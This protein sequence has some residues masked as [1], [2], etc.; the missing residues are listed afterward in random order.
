MSRH[1]AA[2]RV[3]LE[4]TSEGDKLSKQSRRGWGWGEEVVCHGSHTLRNDLNLNSNLT[5]KE[6][7][8]AYHEPRHRRREP[9]V[10]QKK[11]EIDAAVKFISTGDVFNILK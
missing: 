7:A 2:N 1:F 4:V 10:A 3:A 5:V 11:Q 6:V 8:H 9:F